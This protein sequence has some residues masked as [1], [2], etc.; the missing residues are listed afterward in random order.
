MT[1]VDHKRLARELDRR[2]MRRRML[3]LVTL[4]TAAILAVIYLRCGDGWGTGG[5]G[6]GEGGTARPVLSTSD[7]AARCSIRLAAEGL[8]VDGKSMTRDEAITACKGK[9]GADVLITGDARQGDWDELR[10][11]LEAAGIQFFTREPRGVSPSD[12]A[13]PPIPPSPPPPPAQD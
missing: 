2:R 11:S 8:T 10:G 13:P 3:T 12:A 5:K 4:L 6:P 9:M 7:A 1:D